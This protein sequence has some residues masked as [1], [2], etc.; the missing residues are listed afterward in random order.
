[1]LSSRMLSALQMCSETQVLATSEPGD[2]TPIGKLALAGLVRRVMCFDPETYERLGR[3]HHV[4]GRPSVEI[5]TP[6][7]GGWDALHRKG[8]GYGLGTGEIRD[9]FAAETRGALP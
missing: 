1:M 3:G 2:P 8:R 9:E 5:W 6:T 4:G 7:A